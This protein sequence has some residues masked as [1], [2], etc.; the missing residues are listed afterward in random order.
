MSKT[1]NNKDIVIAR[2]EAIF[3]KRLLQKARLERSRKVRN[4]VFLSW[5]LILFS[6]LSYSQE[7]I[8]TLKGKE[9]NNKVRLNFI[10]VSMPSDKFPQLK[11][12][13]GLAGLHYQVPF[14]DWLYGG[15]AFH[16]AV[17][18]DQGGLFTLGAELGINKQLYKNL[19]LDANFHFGGGGGYRKYVNDGAF[20]NPNIGLQYK[21]NNY[22]VG[23]QYSYIDFFSGEIK[24]DA[25]S[26][27]VEIPSVLRL[28]DYKNAH[29]KFIA[30]NDSTDN[31]WQKPIV[32]NVQQVRFDF[33]FPFG[34]SKK[35]NA[36]ELKETLYVLGFEYQK[37]VNENTFLFAHTDAIYKGLRAGF[38][39]L[40]FGAG[41]HPYQSKYINLFTKFG[42]GAAGG[43]IA[44]EGG[45]TMY[46]SAGID[47]KLANNFALS[48]HGGYYRAL[49]GDFEAYT[50]GFGLKYFGLNGGTKTSSEENISYFKTQ[51]ITVSL[52][53]QTYFDVAKT[54]DPD[55]IL[56][57][58]L[59]LLA[60]QFNYDITKNIYLIGEAG[61]AYGGRSGG[62]AHG[63]AGMGIK[64]NSFF[65]DKFYGFLDVV[66]GAAGG[67]GVDTD[68]G[69]VVRPTAGINY[70]LANNFSISVS[71]GKLYSPF[72]NVNSTNINVG[73]NFS[74]ASLSAQK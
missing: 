30:N 65:N 13:M 36:T 63:L 9:L 14:N 44:P 3:L 2:N 21:H 51:A 20:I 34:Q 4:D 74:F 61:F 12:T 33:F 22:S 59:Q 1:E 42:I 68:E 70:E 43:R 56:A 48:G 72:G 37:Y 40:F 26:V 46:P 66:G 25:V 53:N 11:P 16:F 27:F 8:S 19:Y 73:L 28:T 7:D 62:Y 67:A 29:K 10:P 49:D 15:A 32:K 24:D 35:D 52:E 41:Y 6:F 23:V 60:L 64:T 54:D 47:L 69:I 71:G 39:D 31:F 18:G 38:M 58:D 17:T 55:D 50:L 45:L 5:F 57:V